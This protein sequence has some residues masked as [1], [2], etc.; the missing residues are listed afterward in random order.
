M[1]DR[2]VAAVKRAIGL[3]NRHPRAATQPELKSSRAKGPY[4]NSAAQR[5]PR[6]VSFKRPVVLGGA[7]SLPGKHPPRPGTV[8]PVVL[9]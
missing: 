6:M 2:F 7:F 4:R 5:P 3:R 8:I 1:N 9:V